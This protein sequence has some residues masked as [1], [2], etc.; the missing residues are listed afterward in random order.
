MKIRQMMLVC[1]S[2]AMMAGAQDFVTYE[3]F[4]AVG[5]GKTDDQAAIVAAHKAANGKGLP[6]RAA[7]GKTY[8]I[9][10]GASVA[11][12]KTDV[13]FGTASFLIDD[14]VLDNLKAPVFRIEPSGKSFEVKGVATLAQGQ[15]NIGVALPGP[16]LVEAQDANVRH[17]IRYGLNQNKGTPQKEVFLVDASGAVDPCT[18]IIWDYAKVTRLTAHPVDVKPLVVKGGRFTTIANQAESRYSYHG[19]GIDVRRSNVRIENLRHDVTGEGDHGAPYGGFVTVSYSANVTV[20]NCVFTAHKTYRTIGAAGKPVSM[21]SYDISA[22]GSVNVSFVNCRQ[23]TDIHNSRYWGLFGSNYCRNLL[24]DGC[25]FSRFDAHQGVA[26]ATIR[27]SKLGYMGIN[28]IGFGTFLVENTTVHSSNFF[29][30]RSDYGSTW[31]GEFIGRNCT[32]VP[33]KAPGALVNGSSTDWHDFGYPCG[34]PRRIVFD[35]L[36]IDDAR[37]PDKYDGPRI[38]SPFSKKNVAPGYVEKYPYRVTEE[39]VLRNVTTASGKPVNLS[40]N[41]WM[42]R[43]VK[44]VRH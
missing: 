1:A 37:H 22:N 29:N 2:A 30:L 19:R 34:M 35:G 38:F 26:N 15:K 41:A 4:G 24:Y 17:Y 40:P 3:A 11:V 7:D 32:F 20:S 28:A 13:D 27:N 33:S 8:Y 5:D 36:K 16:C 23:T 44:V 21:G 39:V 31:K 14:R 25:E 18:P 42:F 6:V 12:I 43:N 9:G 10:K